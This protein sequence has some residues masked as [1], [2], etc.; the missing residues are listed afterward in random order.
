[1][2]DRDRAI[3]I[4]KSLGDDMN[5]KCGRG[6][7]SG[8]NVITCPDIWACGDCYHASIV[9]EQTEIYVKVADKHFTTVGETAIPLSDPE[10][11]EPIILMSHIARIL[12]RSYAIAKCR[13]REHT[14]T[15]LVRIGKILMHF[16]SD[17]CIVFDF[18]YSFI[19]KIVD[20]GLTITSLEKAMA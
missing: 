4:A 10:S 3:S 6:Y 13:N 7:N 1:M 18:D 5:E 19:A 9:V 20:G 2:D 12:L 17:T 11:V 16:Y 8:G 15:I 14:S